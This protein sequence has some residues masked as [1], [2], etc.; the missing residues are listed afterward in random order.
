[1]DF[2]T[3]DSFFDYV[4]SVI[5]FTLTL[6][7]SRKFWLWYWKIDVIVG[8]LESIDKKMGAIINQGTDLDPEE[9][10][11]T[12]DTHDPL[13]IPSDNDEEQ[14]PDKDSIW[15]PIGVALITVILLF[16]MWFFL[17]L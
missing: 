4:L 3:L 2:W 15:V 11:K 1:M 10:P 8:L 12:I 7:S 13:Y 9:I 17:S 14:E 16:A 6:T 5:V